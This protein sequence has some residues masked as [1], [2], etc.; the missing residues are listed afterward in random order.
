M[1]V[2]YNTRVNP[3]A[4]A[5]R[6]YASHAALDYL[7]TLQSANR[8]DNT[9]SD[10]WPLHLSQETFPEP[11]QN[12][13][14]L[15]AYRIQHI[16]H[17]SFAR[18]QE[19][20]T[21][22]QSGQ[23]GMQFSPSTSG[24]KAPLMSTNN[25][26]LATTSPMMKKCPRDMHMMDKE[27]ANFPTG[28]DSEYSPRQ[29][30]SR[31]RRSRSSSNSTNSTRAEESVENSNVKLRG[32]NISSDDRNQTLTARQRGFIRRWHANFAQ[33]DAVSEKSG[34]IAGALAILIGARPMPVNNFIS[35]LNIGTASEEESLDT[36]YLDVSPSPKHHKR[37]KST[38]SANIAIAN[39]HLSAPTLALVQRY[40]TICRRQRSRTDGRRTVNKGPFRCTFGCGYHTARVFDWRRHEETHEPQELWLCSLC[41]K[42]NSDNP[43]MVSRKDKF[44][45]HA[46]ESHGEVEADKILEDSRLGFV[47]R[48]GLKCDLCGEE[49]DNWEDRCRHILT[50]FEEEQE[51]MAGKRGGDVGEEKRKGKER[52]SG[53]ISG[54][55][56][57]DSKAG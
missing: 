35:R 14:H 2:S 43:F 37:L 32:M 5:G 28:Q 13:S 8:H 29:A 3:T 56:D 51:G 44:L 4:S 47:P 34:D 49:C 22:G 38:T 33:S 17:L 23:F 11:S 6:T 54:G 40:M 24:Y 12:S 57:R 27:N 52:E 25:S 42:F 50:H 41:Y 31:K 19:H 16:P 1:G 30:S 20:A 7:E 10:T 55:S 46:R 48:G 18:F 39:A 36:E 53:S 21:S 9:S 45:R 26:L 15:P